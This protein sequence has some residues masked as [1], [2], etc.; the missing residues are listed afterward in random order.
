MTTTATTP[1][2]QLRTGTKRRSWLWLVAGAL[3][4][5][6]S[7]I[8]LQFDAASAATVGA[9]GGAM[10]ITA[11][12]EYF[13]IGSM[14]RGMSWLW[15]VSGG[16]LVT[17]GLVALLYPARTFFAMA[18]IMGFVFAVIGIMWVVEAFMVRDYNNLWWFNLVAGV[19]TTVM[20][21]WLSGQFLITQAAALLTFAGLW[22]LMRGIADITNFFTIRAVASVLPKE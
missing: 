11:G 16:I 20:G 18:N 1:L 12:V 4:I 19:L 3:W 6:I 21:F 22:A 10:F 15:Y 13:F 2:T 7:V 8:I 9:I 14:M 5:M 17:G